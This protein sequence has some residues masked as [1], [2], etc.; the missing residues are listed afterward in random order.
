MRSEFGILN[1]YLPIQPFRVKHE[2]KIQDTNKMKAI[3]KTIRALYGFYRGRVPSIPSSETPY[4]IL[5][6]IFTTNFRDMANL[7][8]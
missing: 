1:L 8:P 2:M 6:G 4:N 5:K 7:R 3:H